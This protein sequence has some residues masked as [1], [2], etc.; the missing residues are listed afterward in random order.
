MIRY[1]IKNNVKLMFR[2]KWILVVMI[3]APVLVIAI[4]SSAFSDL[5]KS[6]E[7]AGEFRAGYRIWDGSAAGSNMEAVKTAGKEAGITFLEY[8]EGEP[9]EVVKNNGLAGFVEFGADDYT[10]YERADFKMEGITLEY[11]LNRVM[12]EYVDSALY[13]LMP[14]AEEQQIEIPFA[15]IDYMPAVGAEDYY[16]IIYIVFFACMGIVCAANVLS[17]EKKYGIDRKFQVAAVSDGKLYLGKWIPVVVIVS[18]GLALASGITVLLLDIH[19]GNAFVSAGLILAVIM[20][21]AAFGLMIY[22]IFNNMALTVIVVFA[23]VWFMG[24]IGG[25]FETYMYASYPDFLKNLSPIYHANRALVEISCMGHSSYAISCIV[26][27]AAITAVCPVIA[28]TAGRIR[29]RRS[30]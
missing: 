1:L 24:F 11:F 8:P 18:A 17:N 10:V 28:V 2:N 9:E 12:G 14:Q 26:Y 21:G 5:M 7:G 25:S 30:A 3:L 6:Y 16:G 20:A 23:C 13:A 19:W 15:E 27:M 29:K 4:L 22:Y